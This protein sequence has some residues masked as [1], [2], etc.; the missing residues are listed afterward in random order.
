M[1]G[2]ATCRTLFAD[3]GGQRLAAYTLRLNK[4]PHALTEGRTIRLE[5]AT[6]APG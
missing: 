2:Q 6:D 5:G 1:R 3:A 4:L